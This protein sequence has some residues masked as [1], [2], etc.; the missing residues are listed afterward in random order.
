MADVS[1]SQP[2]IEERRKPPVSA[3]AAPT[4]RVGPADDAFEREADAVANSVVQRLARGDDHDG[5]VGFTL[6]AELGTLARRSTDGGMGSAGGDVDDAIATRIE[7]Q[8]GGGSPLAARD[9]TAMESAFGGVD[10]GG[11]RIHSGSESSRLNAAL[12]AEAFTIGQDV[13]FGGPVPDARSPH[14][15]SLLAHELT[16]TLQQSGTAQRTIRRRRIKG[17]PTLEAFDEAIGLRGATAR[18]KYKVKMKAVGLDA[19]HTASRGHRTAGTGSEPEGAVDKLSSFAEGV[20]DGLAVTNDVNDAGEGYGLDVFHDSSPEGVGGDE[21]G[22]IAMAGSSLG[23]LIEFVGLVQA[24]ADRKKVGGFE[25]GVAAAKTVGKTASLASDATSMALSAKKEKVVGDDLAEARKNAHKW[26]QT[27]EGKGEAAIGGLAGIAT[28]VTELYDAVKILYELY[29]DWDVKSKADVGRDTLSALMKGLSAAQGAASAAKAITSS[30]LA[31]VASA[32]PILGLAIS[33]VSFLI[34]IIDLVVNAVG[35]YDSQ[36][37]KRAQRTQVF[38]LLDK[39]SVPGSP[40]RFADYER[41]LDTY[42]K[43]RPGLTARNFTYPDLTAR[44][45]EDK[46][47]RSAS[48]RRRARI[49]VRTLQFEEFASAF[50]TQA[51]EAQGRLDKLDDELTKNDGARDQAEKKVETLNDE[52]SKLKS[53]KDA[54][55]KKSKQAEVD[56]LTAELKE[57]RAARKQLD[58]DRGKAVTD[59]KAAEQ[60]RQ[61]CT[62][63]PAEKELAE[64]TQQYLQL[65]DIDQISWKRLNRTIVN[66]ATGLPALAGDIAIISGAGA[67]VG[68]GLKAA[69]AGAKFGVWGFRTA[70]QAFRNRFQTDDH[71]TTENKAKKY[72]NMIVIT[73]GQISRLMTNRRSAHV[74]PPGDLAGD[75]KLFGSI[76]SQMS[77]MGLPLEKFLAI[78]DPDEAYEKWVTALKYRG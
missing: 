50:D 29:Q 36:K 28:S 12:G 7:R 76:K 78:D 10:F 44:T 31:G 67:P 32:V 40:T 39:P 65:R 9:R 16:H 15:Q 24:I 47:S 60:I 43:L 54:P 6:G 75:T 71:R 74:T 59:R 58:S 61:T 17:M 37:R 66:T 4:L 33:V 57:L 41:K 18:G 27:P 19:L 1:V 68:V 42:E 35:A 72:A 21:V 11:V 62:L 48:H 30:A 2:T 77:A 5:P 23:L 46:V 34:S 8:R 55:T 20:A 38:D 49:V 25:V 45:W 52:I 51:T 63:S 64:E 14:G 69:S 22:Q 3:P 70:K 53:K 26:L 56:K 73:S 13:F